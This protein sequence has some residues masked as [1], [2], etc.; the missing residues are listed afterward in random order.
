MLK[1][2]FSGTD[3]NGKLCGLIGN[4]DGDTRNDLQTPDGFEVKDVTAFGESWKVKG[5][6]CD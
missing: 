2:S 6:I 1:A 4:A 3:Y 5:E